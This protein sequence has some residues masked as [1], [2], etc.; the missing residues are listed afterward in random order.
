MIRALAERAI[1]AL[2]EPPCAICGRTNDRPLDDAVCPACWRAIRPLTP[3]LCRACGDALATWRV[4]SRLAA[5]CPRC[6]RT[7]R[8][9]GRMAAVGAYDGALRDILHAFKY[10][11]RRSV[12]ARLG[13]LM[14]EAG[15]SVLDGADIVVPVPLHPRRQ[16][17]RGFNQA[18]LL[19]KELGPPSMP[20]LR[21][22]V[23]TPPQV[24]LP[25]ARRHRNLRGAFALRPPGWRHLWARRHAPDSPHGL[26]IVLVDDVATTGAT[27]DACARVLVDA[28][29]REVR[30]ITAARVSLSP[31]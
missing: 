6:R 24:S 9:V 30:A 23:H 20:L 2:A 25:A 17:S 18:A 19:A 13:R 22:V 31:L 29:A 14:R 21:R 11:R 1:V 7:P 27:L 3:P 4:A 15:V 28:G 10:Q 5:L 26:T 8:L 12:A 16:F